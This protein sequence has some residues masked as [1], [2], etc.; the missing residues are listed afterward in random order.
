MTPQGVTLTSILQASSKARFTLG[1]K[2]KVELKSSI[3]IGAITETSPIGFTL[4]IKV[5]KENIFF[6]LVFYGPDFVSRQ[7]KRYVST[8]EANL[9]PLG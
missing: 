7:K 2:P 5:E 6:N 3:P 1:V 8:W 9:Q 4:V